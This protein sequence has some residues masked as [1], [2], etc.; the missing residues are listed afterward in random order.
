MASRRRAAA[1]VAGLAG[2]AVL[3]GG[4]IAARRRLLVIEVVGDSMAPVYGRG[5][6]L[7]VRRTRRLR[8]G[9]VVIAH[10]QE[11]GRRDA[12][13]E[14]LASA[15]LLKRL[16]ALPG[17]AVPAAV[18]HA[19]GG[20]DRPVPPGKAVLLGEHPDSADSRTWGFVPMA[21]IAGVVL[22]RLG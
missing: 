5:D 4:L 2:A 19:V 20:A 3:V 14:P 10:H 22:A 13:T 6:R 11:G 15:W 1:G 9:D 8:V 18:A 7:L 12:R 17:D 16:V 21:D